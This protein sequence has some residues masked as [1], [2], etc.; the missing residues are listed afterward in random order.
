MTTARRAGTVS[1]AALSGL[2]LTLGF[3][4]AVAPSRVR[5]AGLDLWNLAS[6]R[7][8]V[9]ETDEQ[10]VVLQRTQEQLAREIEMAE[11]FAARLAD[12]GLTLAE[13]VEELTPVLAARP[14][15]ATAATERFGTPTF[16]HTVAAYAIDKVRQL[17]EVEPTRWAAVSARLDAEYAALK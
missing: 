7:R 15:F 3:S 17:L 11:H 1:A 2:A 8:E 12:G 4:H 14:G 9:R 13:V 16:R 10:K 6:I 5:D